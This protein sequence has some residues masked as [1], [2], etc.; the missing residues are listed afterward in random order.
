MQNQ[1]FENIGKVC[2]ISLETGK[3]LGGWNMRLWDRLTEQQLAGVALWVDAGIKQLRLLGQ[4]Q[5]PYEIYAGQ[6]Q[7]AQEYAERVSQYMRQTLA[8]LADVQSDLGSVFRPEVKDRGTARPRALT[9]DEAVSG[10]TKQKPQT[11]LS[12]S[13]E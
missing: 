7:L 11:D 10:S 6:T 1:A 4:S 2:E 3:R 9:P 13:S 5:N 12:I 8:I